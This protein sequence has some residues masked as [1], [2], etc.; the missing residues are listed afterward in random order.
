MTG[1]RYGRCGLTHGRF[2]RG[3][4]EDSI[5]GNHLHTPSHVISELFGVILTTITIGA[6]T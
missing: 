5:S 1:Y 2:P 3:A 6:R 4:Y